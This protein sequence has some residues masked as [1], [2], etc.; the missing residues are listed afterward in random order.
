M[1]CI[2]AIAR[3]ANSNPAADR[4]FI[5]QPNSERLVL[6]EGLAIRECIPECVPA[7]DG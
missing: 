2:H 5:V 6:V 4:F 7:G 3:E 1:R